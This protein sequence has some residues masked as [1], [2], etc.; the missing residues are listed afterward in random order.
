MEVTSGSL[1]FT[2][3]FTNNGV[4]IGTETTSDGTVTISTAAT[5][6]SP[7]D[8]GLSTVPESHAPMAASQGALGGWDTSWAH[9]ALELILTHGH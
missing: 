7:A 4:I 8:F 6:L 9:A 5:P 1:V 3:G 2:G